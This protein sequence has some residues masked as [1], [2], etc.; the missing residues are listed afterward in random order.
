MNPSIEVTTHVNAPIR[1]VWAYWTRPAHIVK[2]NQASPDWHTPSA[3]SDLRPGGTF[4]WR[5]EAKDGSM[6]FDFAGEFTD[7]VPYGKINYTLGDGRLVEVT[8]AS[9]GDGTRVTEVFQPEN[10]FS[11]DLQRQGWQAILDSFKAYAEDITGRPMMTWSIRIDA[12]VER[13]YQTMLGEESYRAW[14]SAFNP[15]SR[16]MGTWDE[17]SSIRFLGTGEDGQVG[18]M[19]ARIRENKPN[20]FVSIEHLGVIV[21]DQELFEGPDV[22]EWANGFENYTFMPDGNGTLLKIELTYNPDFQ[23]YFDDMWPNAL[24]LLKKLCEE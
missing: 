8:F 9:E 21:G 4:N 12:P 13:V 15:T 14:T 1:K 23:Q 18:G 6:G 19:V 16:Y 11:H 3:E 2:W 24:A 20:R 5:M 10:E 7:V 17:G 22:D